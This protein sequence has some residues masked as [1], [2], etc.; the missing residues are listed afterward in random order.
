[1]SILHDNCSKKWSPETRSPLLRFW[2]YFFLTISILNECCYLFCRYMTNSQ[3]VLRNQSLNTSITNTCC[4]FFFSYFV[5]NFFFSIAIQIGQFTVKTF[6]FEWFFSQWFSCHCVKQCCK[7]IRFCF[8][9]AMVTVGNAM[10][11][12]AWNDRW[13]DSV[14]NQ[15]IPSLTS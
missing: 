2:N 12:D 13:I 6:N 4:D 8:S 11:Y 7:T 14:T 1:M 10:N 3:L 9:W 5:G 15:R